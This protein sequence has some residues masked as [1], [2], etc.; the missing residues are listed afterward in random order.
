MVM[1]EKM[2]IY[3]LPSHGTYCHSLFVPCAWLIV[4]STASTVGTILRC[5]ARS[6]P[7]SNERD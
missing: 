1:V 4:D 5:P 2:T 7:V 6:Y 3:M